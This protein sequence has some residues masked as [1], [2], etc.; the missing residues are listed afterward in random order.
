[1][2]H[3]W[4][5]QRPCVV[6]SI[7]VQILFNSHLTSVFLKQSSVKRTVHGRFFGCIYTVGRGE[8]GGGEGRREEEDEER[9]EEKRK[10]EKRKEEER[11]EEEKREE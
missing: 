8:G 6:H 5:I 4:S 3:A 1:M 10:E 11:E 2:D 7:C 9:E